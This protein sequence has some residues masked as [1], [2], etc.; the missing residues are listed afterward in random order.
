MVDCFGEKSARKFSPGR[1]LLS[2]TSLP[3]CPKILGPF[4]FNIDV[5]TVITF[6]YWSGI[7]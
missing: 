5:E 1:V 7:R 4:G 6:S 2:A 3:L